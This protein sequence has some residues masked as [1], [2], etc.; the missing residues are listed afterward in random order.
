M[1]I[2]SNVNCKSVKNELLIKYVPGIVLLLIFKALY[3]KKILKVPKKK[4]PYTHKYNHKYNIKIF[5]FV[6]PKHAE[7]WYF[8]ILWLS[9]T[10]NLQTIYDTILC[11][12]PY[13]IV[14]N[15]EKIIREFECYFL[16]I[17]SFVFFISFQNLK[18]Y[19][20]KLHLI[21]ATKTSMLP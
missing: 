1:E 18:I 17:L 12:T 21:I 4:I 14:K 11:F 2:C 5:I 6:W 9:S 19:L 13:S 10:K 3:F 20:K 8:W 16:F 7:L 15:W